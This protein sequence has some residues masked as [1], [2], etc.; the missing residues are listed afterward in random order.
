MTTNKDARRRALDIKNRSKALA[1]F[2]E[3]VATG[4]ADDMSGET[5]DFIVQMFDV[6]KMVDGCKTFREKVKQPVTD[7]KTTIDIDAD[8]LREALSESGI[9]KVPTSYD[10]ES[11]KNLIVIIQAAQETLR[12]IENGGG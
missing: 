3:A 2:V 6:P 12:R 9:I 10:G 5:V 7:D 8:A 11:M 1:E 4:N